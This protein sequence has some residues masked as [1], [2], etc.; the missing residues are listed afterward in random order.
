MDTF[1]SI[2]TLEMNS[3]SDHLGRFSSTINK[4][5]YAFNESQKH[6]LFKC[7]AEKCFSSG[8]FTHRK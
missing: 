8:L 5:E 4:N 1:P 7:A 3:S 6:R 2:Y